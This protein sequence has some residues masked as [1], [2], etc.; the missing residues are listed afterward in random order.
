MYPFCLYLRSLSMGRNSVAMRVVR[1]L[2]TDRNLGTLPFTLLTGQDKD[3][4]VPEGYNPHKNRGPRFEVGITRK[5]H[6]RR[7]DHREAASQNPPVLQ[8]HMYHEPG[9]FARNVCDRSTRCC[10]TS[11]GWYMGG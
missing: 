11:M 3:R 5:G 10:S 2:L 9:N 8:L 7:M 1:T 4:L 6:R